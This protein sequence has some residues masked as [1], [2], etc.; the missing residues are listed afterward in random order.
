M[1]KKQLK[2]PQ[3]TQLQQQVEELT[4][5]WKRAVADYQNLEK[6]ASRQIEAAAKFGHSDLIRKL[7]KVYQDLLLASGHHPTEDWIRLIA[8]DFRGILS[9]EG[10]EEIAA[11]G[12]RFNPETMEC[13]AQVTG[14]ETQVTKVVMRGFTLGGRVLQPVKVEVGQGDK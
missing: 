12:Q 9:D 2:N 13:V 4:N 11:L 7:L 14:P 6:R 10:V 5:N 8:E 1:V 3:V